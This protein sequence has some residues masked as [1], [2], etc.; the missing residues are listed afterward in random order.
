VTAPGGSNLSDD[1]LELACIEGSQRLGPDV[2]Q[3]GQ[4][5]QGAEHLHVIAVQDDDAVARAR[6]PVLGFHGDAG[7]FSGLAESHRPA[8]ALADVARSLLGESNECNVT[9]HLVS[10]LLD[11]QP[12]LP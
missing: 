4:L 6:G 8:G 2:A 1:S 5:S 11:A 7:S 3:R 9:G 10:F 12:T